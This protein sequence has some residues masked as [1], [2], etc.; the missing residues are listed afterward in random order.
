MVDLHWLPVKFR[1]IF[2]IILFTFKAVHGI[3]LTYITSLLSFKHS[4]YNL[5]SVGNNTLGRPEIKSAKT[6]GDRAFAI[7]APV[8]WN[9]LLPNLRAIDNIASFKKQLKAHLFRKAY[10]QIF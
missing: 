3:A 7:A 4:R 2:K 9:T 6:T 10:F 1:I 5:R 8:L